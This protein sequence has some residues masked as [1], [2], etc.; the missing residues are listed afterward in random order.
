MYT[1]LLKIVQQAG[2][3]L[4]V[5]LEYPHELQEWHNSHPLAPEKLEI[6]DNMSNYCSEIAKKYDIKVVGVKKL[7]LNLGNK[8]KY[9]VH[10]KNFQLYLSLGMKLNKI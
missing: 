1:Q 4:K 8:S 3:I 9:V 7:V 5:D 10:C 6:S 2:Y